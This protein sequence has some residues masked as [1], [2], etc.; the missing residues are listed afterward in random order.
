MLE[1]DLGPK[2]V[3]FEKVHSEGIGV[4]IVSSLATMRS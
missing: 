1:F 2:V 4:A 3:P